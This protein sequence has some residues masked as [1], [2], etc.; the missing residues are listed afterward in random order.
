MKLLAFAALFVL[1]AYG[2]YL[3]SDVMAHIVST[4]RG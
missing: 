4:L 3:P 2:L 1:L